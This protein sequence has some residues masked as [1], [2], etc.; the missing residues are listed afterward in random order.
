MVVLKIYEN[1]IAE[2]QLQHSA[3]K[4]NV[5]EDFQKIFRFDQAKSS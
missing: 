5:L 1:A 3:N 2:P 4:I